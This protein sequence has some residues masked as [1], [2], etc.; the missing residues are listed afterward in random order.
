MPLRVSELGKR[1]P[2]RILKCSHIYDKAER[3]QHTVGFVFVI[4]RNLLNSFGSQVSWGNIPLQIEGTYYQ[5]RN[6]I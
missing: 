1:Q 3:P 5:E 2:L 4:L 6:S